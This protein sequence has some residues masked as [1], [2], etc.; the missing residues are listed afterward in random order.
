MKPVRHVLCPIDFS[1]F[2]NA[3]LDHHFAGGDRSRRDHCEQFPPVPL[4]PSG[5]QQT[6][7]GFAATALPAGEY[8]FIVLSGSSAGGR[9]FDFGVD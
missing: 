6:F 4:I 9:M 8:A 5:Q 3:A 2:S 7:A 1:E